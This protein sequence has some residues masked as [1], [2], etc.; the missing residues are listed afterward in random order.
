MISWNHDDLYSLSLF[1]ANQ[2]RA[3][4]EGIGDFSCKYFDI[5]R[6]WL[7]SICLSN[8]TVKWNV[9]EVITS[10]VQH[11]Q[12]EVNAFFPS[13]KQTKKINVGYV[14]LEQKLQ[15]PVHVCLCLQCTA[16]QPF[17]QN[18]SL[19]RTNFYIF[20]FRN[21]ESF[22]KIYSYYSLH[23]YSLFS[24]KKKKKHLYSLLATLF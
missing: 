9:G 1:L 15:A 3:G 14:S 8:V 18:Q 22:L 20:Q 23:L 16:L 5:I 11:K 6:S 13:A 12:I 19:F 24:K 7:L 17:V 21:L 4:G 2:T 10:V